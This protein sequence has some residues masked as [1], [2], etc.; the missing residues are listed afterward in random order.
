MVVLVVTVAVPEQFGMPKFC[1]LLAA[2]L[3]A[4]VFH[5]NWLW[6][7]RVRHCVSTPAIKSRYSLSVRFRILDCVVEPSRKFHVCH[8][9]LEPEPPEP[10]PVPFATQRA[11]SKYWPVVHAT[12]ER[13]LS[14][15][16]IPKSVLA[17]FPALVIHTFEPE[18]T[19]WHACCSEAIRDASA[20]VR[21]HD[22][23][24]SAFH[25]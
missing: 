25:A 15:L 17:G 8:A 5:A 14:K 20:S 9:Q 6:V 11:P 22:C 23:R 21:I 16:G 7:T 4:P 2:S 19:L 24:P 1:Q 3:P 12:A 10:K 18:G 13:H